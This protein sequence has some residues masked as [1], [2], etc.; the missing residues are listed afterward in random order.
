MPSARSSP[1]RK[2]NS[3]SL[4]ASSHSRSLGWTCDQPRTVPICLKAAT[5]GIL[6]ALVAAWRMSTSASFSAGKV[7]SARNAATSN[8]SPMSGSPIRRVARESITPAAITTIATASINPSH[9]SCRIRRRA[10]AE[11]VNQR[12]PR[13]PASEHQAVPAT[14]SF[15]IRVN[16]QAGRL[17]H[18][19]CASVGEFL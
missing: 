7:L 18:S 17:P 19:P 15:W 2:S 11:S 14:R 6:V 13:E 8:G 4:F 1:L 10:S 3:A 9:K 16:L 12:G 5:S